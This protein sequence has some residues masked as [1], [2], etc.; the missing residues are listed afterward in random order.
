MAKPKRR[1]FVSCTRVRGARMNEVASMNEAR[2]AALDMALVEEIP[3]EGVTFD[4]LALVGK[5][6]VYPTAEEIPADTPDGDTNDDE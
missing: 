5:I 1:M 6:H 3:K 2:L 4:V